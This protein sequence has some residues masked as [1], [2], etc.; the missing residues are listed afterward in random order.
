LERQSWLQAT[1]KRNSRCEERVFGSHRHP[2]TGFTTKLHTVRPHS[3]LTTFSKTSQQYLITTSPLSFANTVSSTLG[4]A[5][6]VAEESRRRNER[7]R[8]P[9]I[10]GDLRIETGTKPSVELWTARWIV[11]RYYAHVGNFVIE[12]LLFAFE[13]VCPISSVRLAL[14]TQRRTPNLLHIRDLIPVL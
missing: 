9:R 8:R 10:L 14:N 5:Y 4:L 1:S 11:S 2:A 3:G 12:R 7:N 13:L 6:R